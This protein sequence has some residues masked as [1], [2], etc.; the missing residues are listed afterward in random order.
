MLAFFLNKL[1][2]QSGT[3]YQINPSCAENSG[4]LGIDVTTSLHDF[5]FPY[6]FIIYNEEYDYEAEQVLSSNNA[7]FNNIFY[8]L[9][10]PIFI[11][12]KFKIIYFI[13]NFNFSHVAGD[14]KLFQTFF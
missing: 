1:D 10:R 6:T 8:C 3:S 4:S 2:A 14:V 9:A 7:V 11:T 5:P 13:N 12:D